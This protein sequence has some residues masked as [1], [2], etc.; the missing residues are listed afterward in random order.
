MSS[1]N[2]IHIIEAAKAHND[3]SNSVM[4]YTGHDGR[5]TKLMTVVLDWHGKLLAAGF[6]GR[7]TCVILERRDDFHDQVYT[8]TRS[9]D[10]E[11][12]KNLFPVIALMN[13]SRQWNQENS[14]ASFTDLIE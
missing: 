13:Q 4:T 6:P 11:A 2:D 1:L 10:S 5:T 9:I 14:L 7:Q 8:M 3:G 12:I